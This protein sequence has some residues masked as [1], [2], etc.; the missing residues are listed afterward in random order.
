[1][2]EKKH[3][4][5]IMKLSNYNKLK[6]TVKSLELKIDEKES[7]IRRGNVTSIEL[8]NYRRDIKEIRYKLEDTNRELKVIDNALDVL[9][10]N[11][12]VIIKEQYINGLKRDRVIEIIDR[13]LRRYED[14]RKNALDKISNYIW[15]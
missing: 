15:I 4:S 10:K 2:S 7:K 13:S 11:E 6:V 9:D 1:M 12:R 3:K 5:T 8:E 14:I